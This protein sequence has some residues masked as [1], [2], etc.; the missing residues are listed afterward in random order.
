MPEQ[1]PAGATTASGVVPSPIQI[2]AVEFPPQ[3]RVAYETGARDV[4]IHQQVW[5]LAGTMQIS[6]G[7]EQYL[8]EAGDCLALALD[9]P[10]PALE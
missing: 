5:V 4:A 3:A 7:D 6:V 1:Q 2:V 8:L 10:R 9:R